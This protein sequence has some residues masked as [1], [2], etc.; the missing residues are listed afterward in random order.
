[1]PW[2]NRNVE[3]EGRLAQVFIDDRFKTSAP[4]EE[5]PRLAWFGIY[6][7][8][9]PG[10]GFWD[11]EETDSL[12]AV[13]DDLIRLCEQFGKGWAVYVLRIATRGMREYY[14]Y[15]GNSVDFISVVPGLLAQHPDYR[16]EYEET[17]DPG[18]RRY[19]SCLSK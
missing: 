12:D 8:R 16:I 6:C 11:P 4:L 17:R 13:E 1:M 5:L 15:M 18:W 19:T 9:A 10:A 7:Q 14:V 2:T 3:I